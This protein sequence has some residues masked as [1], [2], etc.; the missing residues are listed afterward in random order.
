MTLSGCIVAFA[1]IQSKV[2]LLRRYQ[3][4]PIRVKIYIS[5]RED[6]RHG[7]CRLAQ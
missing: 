6:N 7:A 1:E 2:S 3:L 5:G 4:A